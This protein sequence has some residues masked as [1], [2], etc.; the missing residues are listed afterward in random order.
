MIFFIFI[1]I[2]NFLAKFFE[3][4]IDTID[5]PMAAVLA[6]SLNHIDYFIPL[7]SLISC[8]FIYGVDFMDRLREINNPQ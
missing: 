3:Y 7:L 2:V 8:E 1:L 4:F 6:S 5:K